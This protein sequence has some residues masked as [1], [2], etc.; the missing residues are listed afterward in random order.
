MGTTGAAP[1]N[2]RAAVEEMGL[3]LNN[4]QAPCLPSVS[5]DG[6]GSQTNLALRAAGG[7]RARARGTPCVRCG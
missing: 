5:Y 3:F 6:I 1:T 7:Q 2:E 4:A